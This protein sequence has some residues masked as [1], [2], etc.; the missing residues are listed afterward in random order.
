MAFGRRDSGNIDVQCPNVP[1]ERV[2]MHAEHFG[3]DGPI[4]LCGFECRDNELFFEFSDSLGTKDPSLLHSERESLN[5]LSSGVRVFT[6][7]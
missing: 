1:S 7:D 5:I 6:H 2:D 3:S 4:A